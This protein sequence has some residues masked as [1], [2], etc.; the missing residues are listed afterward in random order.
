M[1]IPLKIPAVGESITE[2]QIGQWFKQ[3]GQ[4]VAKD[5]VLA[6]IE[7]DKATVELVAP[8]AGV[9]EQVL[10]QQGETAQVGEVIGQ[11]A[12]QGAASTTPA[13]VESSAAPAP[14]NGPVAQ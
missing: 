12:A 14:S 10:K 5:E 6:E 7:S 8:E 1:S 4:A 13:P 11:L 3:P 9:L 2:V